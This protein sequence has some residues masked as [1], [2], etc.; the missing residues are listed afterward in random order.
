MLQ[1]ALHCISMKHKEVGNFNFEV[2]MQR[3][4]WTNNERKKRDDEVLFKYAI[5]SF[6]VRS[7]LDDAI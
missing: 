6:S 2:D 7:I 3:R 1:L 4:K 5:A